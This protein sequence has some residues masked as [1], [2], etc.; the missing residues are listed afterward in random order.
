MKFKVNFLVFFVFILSNGFCFA[1]DSADAPYSVGFQHYKTYDESRSYIV[2]K[3]TISRPLL[4]HFWYPSKENLKKEPY[5]FKNYIDLIS[6]R[7]DFN[8]ASSEVDRN[9]FNFVNAYAGFA[10]QHLGVDTSL[11][12]QKILNSSVI[13]QYGIAIAK[14]KNNFP[15]II[16]A[17]S[18]SKS[19]VQ[20]HIIC[21]YLASH[22]YL[23]IAVGSAGANSLNRRN[24][25]ESIM[26]Q[27]NDM[28]FTLS[29]L[30][31]CL[32]IKYSSLGVMGFSSGGV[33]T[34]IFQMRNKK[35]KAVFSMDGGQEYGTYISLSKVEGFNLEKTNVPY[36]LLHNNYENFSVYPFYNSIVSKEKYRFRMPYLDHNGF[37][38]Y[39]RFFDL[40]SSKNSVS[41][42]CISYD[43]ISSTALTFFNAYLK[44]KHV[45]NSKSELSFQNNEY[46]KPITSDNSMITKLGNL[47]L[48]DGIGKAMDFIKSN[49]EIFIKKENEINILSKMFRDSYK[50]EAKELLLYNTKNHPNSW[51]AHFELGFTYKLYS[52]LSLAKESLLKAQQLNPENTEINKLLN[53][54]NELEKQQ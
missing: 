14:S 48:S 20:N 4:I 10:K 30:E 18:N 1:Q 33:A 32:K 44:P 23:V 31:D 17:P 46:I 34:V 12:T 35:V 47:I 16:Y 2:N 6:L 42:F 7:E 28:E 54:I 41:K 38:S 39:W 8:K 24:N 40:C 37:V 50:D 3:D 9:S 52:E 25:P 45:S 15:L 11:T 5:S 21:E 19:A 27:V 13:A 51:Q 53:E 36:C 26:A 43:Y 49:Q 22:G 29:Y